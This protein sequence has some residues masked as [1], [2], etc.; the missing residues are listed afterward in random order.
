VTERRERVL[1]G[2]R[3]RRKGLAGH[4]PVA[5]RSITAD[6]FALV[7]R[8]AVTLDVGHVFS[9]ADAA[10]AHRPV[11]SREPTGKVVLEL[12]AGRGSHRRR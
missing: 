4:E 7:A 8:G 12:G 11:E 5:L 10:Q 2:D 9:L 6:A 1:H 3:H